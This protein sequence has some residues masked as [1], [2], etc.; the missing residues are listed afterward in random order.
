MLGWVLKFGSNPAV[1]PPAQ[2]T[3]LVTHLLEKGASVTIPS[4]KDRVPALHLAAATGVKT[5]YD[6]VKRKLSDVAAGNPAKL[7]GLL[8]APD[9]CKRT[10]LHFAAA[11]GRCVSGL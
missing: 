8:K 9:A 3:K 2:L 5:V 11:T 7:T 10:A 6:A 1:L 4:F